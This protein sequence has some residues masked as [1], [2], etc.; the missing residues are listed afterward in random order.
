MPRN[1]A[2]LRPAPT[3]VALANAR[4]PRRAKRARAG[5]TE[6]PFVSA[7][8]ATELLTPLGVRT[9]VTEPDLEALSRLAAEA[10]SIASALAGGGT[11][12]SPGVIN[13][14]AARATGQVRLERADAGF[15]AAVEWSCP[16]VGVEVARR[17]V[18]E[19]STLDPTR[20]RECARPECTLLFYDITR[21]NTQRWHAEDPCGWHERQAR[22][23]APRG[24]LPK[25]TLEE[26]R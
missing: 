22:H 13:A 17:L 20:L 14:M 3:L 26:T 23:R 18:D 12:P 8:Q 7:A 10:S 16:D 11:P 24:T 19:L 15:S 25:T 6:D 2:P 9:S 5:R 21:S 1:A 4:R